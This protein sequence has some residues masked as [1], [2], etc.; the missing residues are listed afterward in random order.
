MFKTIITFYLLFSI[1][2]TIAQEKDTVTNI[3]DYQKEVIAKLTG[4]KAVVKNRFLKQRANYKERLLS[5]EYLASELKKSGWSFE[6]QKYR[7]PQSNYFLDLF[8]QPNKGINLVGKLSATKPTKKHII[9]GAHYDTERNTP[10]AVDNASG[11]ALCLALAKKLQ[12]LKYRKYNVVIAF[13]DQEEDDE[14]GSEVFVQRIQNSNL[15]VH[16]VHIFDLIGWDAD[17]DG[18]LTLQSPTPF[19]ERIYQNEAQLR[20]IQLKIIGGAGSDNKPFL[21]A[22]YATIHPFEEMDDSTPYYHS[23]QDTYETINFEFL[24]KSTRYI[25]CI[26]TKILKNE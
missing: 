24:E 2:S 7:T 25:A 16:S 13:F 9:L 26:L 19:L 23:S 15:D 12:E 18:A 22:G 5:A 11:V 10:G 21:K 6:F 14:V 3:I 17:G 1:S 4:E 20:D 8:F